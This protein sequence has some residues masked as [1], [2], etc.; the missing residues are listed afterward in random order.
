MHYFS[1]FLHLYNYEQSGHEN[2]IIGKKFG[3]TQGTRR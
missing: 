3:G 1:L 2:K